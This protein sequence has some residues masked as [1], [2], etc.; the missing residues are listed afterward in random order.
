LIIKCLRN[1]RDCSSGVVESFVISAQGMYSYGRFTLEVTYTCVSEVGLLETGVLDT[2]GVGL[3]C[4]LIA[5]QVASILVSQVVGLNLL[6]QLGFRYEQRSSRHSLRDTESERALSGGST[7]IPCLAVWNLVPT[8]GGGGSDPN[9]F[10]NG[11]T[12]P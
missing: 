3:A 5:F 2:F 1:Y 6:N 8:R 9:Q 4:V 11:P 12:G 7:S 10:G